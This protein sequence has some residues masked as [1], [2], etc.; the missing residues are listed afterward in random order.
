MKIASEQ[1]RDIIKVNESRNRVTD[2]LSR[3]VGE[4]REKNLEV[5]M[6]TCV[7]AS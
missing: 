1:G 3:G 6:D 4:G 5:G 2:V 7:C